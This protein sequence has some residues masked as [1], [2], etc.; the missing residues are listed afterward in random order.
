[1][2]AVLITIAC[3]VVTGTD[4]ARTLVSRQA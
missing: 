4:Q 2:A 1:M 3:V